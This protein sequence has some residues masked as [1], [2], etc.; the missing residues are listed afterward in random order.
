[1]AHWCSCAFCCVCRLSWAAA[2][3]Q[4][5]RVTEDRVLVTLKRDDMRALANAPTEKDAQAM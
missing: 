4:W 3:Y 5:L 2:L 1:M